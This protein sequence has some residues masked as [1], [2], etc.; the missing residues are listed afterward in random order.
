MTC[1]LKVWIAEEKK[2]KK[3]QGKKKEGIGLR[4][5]GLVECSET[6]V[7]DSNLFTNKF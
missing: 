6:I 7:S 4:F 2:K 1:S 3:K 5:M